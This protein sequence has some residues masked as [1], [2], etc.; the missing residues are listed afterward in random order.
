M[1]KRKNWS[2][3]D[4]V[5]ALITFKK[6]EESQINKLE[7]SATAEAIGCTA[8]SLTMCMKNFE[9]IKT[10]GKSGLSHYGKKQLEVF[11]KF[12]YILP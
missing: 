12:Y 11:N 1:V 6:A 10:G 2:E 4:Y 8:G 9:Y 5:Q 7:L 3:R